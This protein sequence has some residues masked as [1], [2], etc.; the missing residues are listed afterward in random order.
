MVT[1]P[2]SKTARLR[3]EYEKSDGMSSPLALPDDDRFL[4]AAGCIEEALATEETPPA[5]KACGMFLVWDVF[6]DL[7]V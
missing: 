1:D 7:N 5:R 4:A 2:I 6:C 3:A